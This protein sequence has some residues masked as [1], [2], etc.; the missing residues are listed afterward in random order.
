MI[1][2]IVMWKLKEHALGATAAENAA[3]MKEMLEA[4]MQTIPTLA[5]I[6]VSLETF[7]DTPA[8]DVVLYSEFATREDLDIY[9]T[10]PAHQK[11]VAFVKEVA[12]ER[13]AVDYVI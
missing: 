1:K 9:Q 13:R 10:H 3:R 12:E 4:L 11:C 2:H 8:S 5:H 6:E 7:A